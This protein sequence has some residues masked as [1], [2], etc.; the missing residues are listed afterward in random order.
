MKIFEITLFGIT[1]APS[2]YGLMYALGFLIGYWIIL[3]R[4]KIEEDALDSLLIYLFFGV[5]LGGRLGYVLFYNLSYYL[6]N[7]AKIL[8]FW[9]G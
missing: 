5:M 7:P 4:R 6:E 3:R 1:I 9:N 2:Y 8:A